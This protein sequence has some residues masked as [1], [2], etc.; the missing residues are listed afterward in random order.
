MSRARR[1]SFAAALCLVALPL[2]FFHRPLFLGEA[3][4]PGD[5][6]SEVLPYRTLRPDPETQ[7]T[8]WNVLRFD[9][10][11]Q[12]YPWRLQAARALRGGMIPL[13]N[14]FQFA[15]KGGT[16]LLANS[17]SAPLY[18]PNLLYALF[19]GR[20]FWYAFGLSAAIHMLVATW[21]MFS[22]LRALDRSIAASLLG[23]AGWGFSAP[24]VCWLS[25]P[26]FLCVAA[27]IPWILL[28][29]YYARIAPQQKHRRTATLGA[30]A[31][32]GLMLLG[33]HLQI[34]LYG[35]LA[36]G[37]W[38]LWLGAPANGRSLRSW[39]A[40]TGGAIFALG[41]AFCLSAPQLLP[42]LELSR[43]SHRAASGFPT[44]PMYQ[45]YAA[46][47]LPPRNLLTMLFP[48]F[49]GHPN[50]GNDWNDLP[51]GN[52]YGEWAMYGGVLPLLLSLFAIFAMRQKTT[53][54]E[55]RRP[56]FFFLTLAA[57]ALLLAMGSP[58]TMLFFFFVPG[59]SQTGNPARVLILWTFAVAALSAFGLDALL[60]AT[61]ERKR[62][63]ISLLVTTGIIAGTMAV[64][65]M[66]AAQFAVSL[67]GN[68]PAPMQIAAPALLTGGT[69]LAVSLTLLTAGIFLPA[70]KRSLVAPLALLLTVADLC[71]WGIGY[72][73]S[74]PP[75]SI[76]PVTPGIAWLQKNAP[77][78]LIAA[79]NNR[80]GMTAAAPA[81]ALLPPNAATVYGLHD[82]AGY[83]SLFPGAYKK[84]AQKANGIDPS[85]PENGNIVFAK[86][87][88]AAVAMGARYILVPPTRVL[89]GEE[90][91]AHDL[92]RV[93]YE[94]TDMRIYENPSGRKFVAKQESWPLSFRIGLSLGVMAVLMLAGGLFVSLRAPR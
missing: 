36:V 67:Y 13:T 32:G 30:G 92:Q 14:P 75:Q 45:S 84:A 53:P 10:I 52:N 34:A 27:W 91:A 7:K 17:Q 18:P 22:L 65:C 57:I 20:N 58:L 15:N 72:N 4:L 28:L 62:K 76:Y 5:L 85:P 66:M 23:A 11:A 31:T 43:V 55:T 93:V 48:N 89:T 83:D 78:D 63:I 77:N 73:P 38:A 3:F 59:V 56:M 16:P 12:F 81:T 40:W 44:W 86:S 21:G 54:W 9:G 80:W 46:N 70:E 37:L 1:L 60:G 49:F 8:A 42:T 71:L 26:T 82:V 74:V 29:I 79:P 51:V 19:V 24:V 64:S 68:S 94:G 39:A 35:L 33:G 88:D 90:Q 47:A 87:A 61:I 41:L 25:L 2:L 69:L 50:D 6:L